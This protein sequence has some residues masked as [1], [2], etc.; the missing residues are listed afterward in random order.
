M[1]PLPEFEP[2]DPL[3]HRVLYLGKAE[4]SLVG[5]LKGT[6]FM[7]GESGRSTVRRTF[8]ALLG[9]K[10]IPRPSRIMNPD[11]RQLMTMT[12]NYAFTD[13]DDSKLTEWMVSHLAIRVF[14]SSHASLGLLERAV[15]A[16]LR[17]PLDQEQRPFWEPN[18]WRIP[19]AAA[20]KRVRDQLRAQLA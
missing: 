8:G 12:A 7:T 14:A 9:F 11:R 3:G 1:L 17:P 5:R 13:E 19:V 4:D 16:R 15:G 2:H 10:P 6:H 20:R 18:P